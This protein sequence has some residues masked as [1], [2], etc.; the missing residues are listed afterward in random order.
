MERLMKLVTTGLLSVLAIASP[1]ISLAQGTV[2]TPEFVTDR[3]DFTESSEV[4]GRGLVQV[5]SGFTLEGDQNN[6]AI[7]TP[8]ILARIGLTSRVELR[9]GGEGFLR[10]WNSGQPGSAVSGGSDMEIG[11]KVKVLNFS[12]FQAGVIPA[13]SIPTNNPAFSSGAYD[14]SIKATWATTLPRDFDLSG[15]FNV[16]SPTDALGRFTQ[17]AVSLSLGHELVGGWGG[18]WEAF[19]FTPMERGANTGWTLNSGV[20]RSVGRDMQIDIEAGRG[21]TADAPDWFFGFGFAIRRPFVP[22]R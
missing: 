14:P 5:E 9:V 13:V 21:V 1:A 17:S 6:R 20:T 3:P 16:S 22:R 8:A 7:T 15:N 18:Y 4:V 19:S 10:S 2:D 11:A 12:N